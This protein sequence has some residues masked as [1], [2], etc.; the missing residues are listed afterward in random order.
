MFKRSPHTLRVTLG[1]AMVVALALGSLFGVGSASAEGGAVTSHS[2]HS[3]FVGERRVTVQSHFGSTGHR[4]ARHVGA[5]GRVHI[6]KVYPA[7]HGR[8]ARIEYV[9]TLKLGPPVSN[10]YAVASKHIS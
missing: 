8:T 2:F 7:T 3:V 6:W 5:R 10:F 4:V 1:P 9:T